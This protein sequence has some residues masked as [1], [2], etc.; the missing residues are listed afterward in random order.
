[1][2]QQLMRVESYINVMWTLSLEMAFYC[3]VVGLYVLGAHR[4][5][6]EMSIGFAA[7][8]IIGGGGLIPGLYFMGQ[9]G[10]RA[11]LVAVTLAFVAGLALSVTGRRPLV[12]VGSLLLGAMALALMVLNQEGRAWYFLLLPATMFAGTAIY[13]AERGETSR[14][15]AVAAVAVL[16]PIA[17]VNGPL[18]DHMPGAT[19][20]QVLDANVRWLIAIL[21]VVA[22]FLAGRAL[23]HRTIPRFLVL[24]GMMSYSLYLLHPLIYQS[25]ATFLPGRTGLER[26]GIFLLSYVLLFAGSWLTYRYV[27]TPTQQWGRSVARWLDRRYGEDT[28]VSRVSQ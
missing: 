4:R 10:V 7:A 5:S 11:V 14:W 28:S 9:F 6:A 23:R 1:M 24:L 12:V 13:R 21:A 26:T 15:K 16:V 18:Y 8:S 20:W 19:V 17:L 25:F 22:V 2:L 27:E 3:M